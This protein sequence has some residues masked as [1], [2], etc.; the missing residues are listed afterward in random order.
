ML[1]SQ[2]C[3]TKWEL[4]TNITSKVTQY[5]NQIWY[6]RT[7]NKLLFSNIQI[8]LNGEFEKVMQLFSFAFFFLTPGGDTPGCFLM[9]LSQSGCFKK[10]KTL[11]PTF[12]KMCTLKKRSWLS[13]MKTI[14]KYVSLLCCM[15]HHFSKLTASISHLCLFTIC[16]P[17]KIRCMRRWNLLAGL[18]NSL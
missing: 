4:T 2:D 1:N 9:L 14:F 5:W 12:K 10:N 18:M 7:H 15:L 8:K 6:S 16:V 11:L 17:M 3:L 13:F